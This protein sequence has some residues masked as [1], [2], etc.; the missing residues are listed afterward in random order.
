MFT[1]ALVL[2]VFINT[3]KSESKPVLGF[4]IVELFTLEGCAR[5]PPT[6]GLLTRLKRKKLQ[7]HTYHGFTL[8]M[9]GAD[10]DEKI[11]LAA[12]NFENMKPVAA[13]CSNLL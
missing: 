12:P 3:H 6:D 13:K 9:I 11:S 2:L 7:K 8:L 5:C 4:A 10:L 1:I